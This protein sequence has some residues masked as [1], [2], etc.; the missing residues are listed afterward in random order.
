MLPQAVG[1][2]NQVSSTLVGLAIAF[3]GGVSVLMRP[4]QRML[5]TVDSRLEKVEGRLEKLEG[6]VEKLETSVEKLATSV[7]VLSVLVALLLVSAAA[8]SA[9]QLTR[10]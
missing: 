9:I 7:Q 4:S 2:L 5:E 6:S 3:F 1:V 10:S 8:A